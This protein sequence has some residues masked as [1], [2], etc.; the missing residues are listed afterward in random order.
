[1]RPLA[2]MRLTPSLCA[3]SDSDRKVLMS[4]TRI[5]AV[6]VISI[7]PWLL[8]VATSCSTSSSPPAQ[9]PTT[10]ATARLSAA[11][12]PGAIKPTVVLVHGAW[13]DASSWDGEVAALQQRGYE[14]R[15]IANPLED[16]TSD[17]ATVASFLHTIDRARG[18]RGSLVRRIRHHREAADEQSQRQGPRVCRRRRSGRRRDE[19]ITRSG[20]DSVLKHLPEDQLFDKV[21][22]TRLHR[23][24]AVRPL[25]EEGRVP[26]GT[27]ATTCPQTTA[28]RLWATPA[29]GLDR[30]VRKSGTAAAWRTIPSWYFIGRAT[31]SSRPLRRRPHGRARTLPP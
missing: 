24:G 29:R 28:T 15:A 2:S 27:S 8:L 7:V 20:A 16:L 14:V 12:A 6:A 11:P 17:A 5:R 30:R 4:G 13:A 3:L 25:P 10:S 1:M 26:A 31:R 22:K 18:A 19:R 21:A 23:E 9:T